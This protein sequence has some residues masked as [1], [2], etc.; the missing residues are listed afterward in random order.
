MRAAVTAVP[1]AAGTAIPGL[2][3]ETRSLGLS[4]VLSEDFQ[5]R[6]AG[7]VMTFSAADLQRV[8][9]AWKDLS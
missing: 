3:N 8:S 5:I 4:P 7:C 6:A 9:V 2:Q 1:T